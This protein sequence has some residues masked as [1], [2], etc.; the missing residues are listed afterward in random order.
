MSH[1]TNYRSF[2]EITSLTR[3]GTKDH[4]QQ[5]KIQLANTR[6]QTRVAKIPTYKHNI[7]KHNIRTYTQSIYAD[8]KLKTWFRQLFTR[9]SSTG[10]YCWG[11]Y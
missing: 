2:H 6:T 3:A 10:R 9:H 4:Y 5:Q 1:L 7:N 8:A 11:T